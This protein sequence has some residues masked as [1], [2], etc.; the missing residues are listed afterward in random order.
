MSNELIEKL[1]KINTFLREN[2]PLDKI[3]KHYSRGE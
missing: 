3:K 2:Y 1:Y